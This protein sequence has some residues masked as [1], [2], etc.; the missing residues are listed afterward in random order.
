MVSVLTWSFLLDGTEILSYVL[1]GTKIERNRL[2]ISGNQATIQ[3]IKNIT[4]IINIT[5]GMNIIIKR[6]TKY[7]FRGR[8]KIIKEEDNNIILTCFDY[9]QELK[10]LLFSKSYDINIDSQAGEVA[11]IAEDIIIN[12]GFNASV[13]TSTTFL[14][15]FNSR[16]KSRLNRLEVLT[17][18]VNYILYYDYDSD[19]VKFEPIGLNTYANPLIIGSN[20]YNVPIWEEDLESVRNKIRIEGAYKEDTFIEYFNGTGSQ[21]TFTLEFSPIITELTVDNGAGFITQKLGIEN[22]SENYDYTTDRD[23]KTFTFETASIPSAGSNNIIM[24]YTGRVPTPVTKSN[25][26]SIELYGVTQEED[27]NFSDVVT[28]DDA[29]TRVNELLSLLSFATVS[30]MLVTDEY[31]LDLGNVIYVND[32]NN[33][34]RS[35]NYIVHGIVHNY[36]EPVDYVKVG[37]VDFDVQQFFNSVEERIRAL[38]SPDD[39]LSELL[40]QIFELAMI[41]NYDASYLKVSKASKDSGVLYWDDDTQGTWDD[42]DWGDDTEESFVI[43]RIVQRNNTYREFLMDSEF[44]DV[45]NTTATVDSTLNTI[46]FSSGQVF[47][48]LA[49]SLGVAHSFFTL[50]IGNQSGSLLY[51]VSADNGVSFQT[52]SSL[53]VRTA[54]VSSD[55]TGIILRITENNSSSA[56]LEPLRSIN[57]TLINPAISLF[58]EVN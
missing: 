50:N 1:P 32:V 5:A 51:E 47:Q 25:P 23:L 21:D 36:P 34:S 20:V 42:F 49:V 8:I 44:V 55:A 2:N 33:P 46:S 45:L 18:V 12:G 56:S 57:D 54:Y 14:K 58:S 43:S 29:E 10:Y 37:D 30:T 53:N 13:V 16:R 6:G 28:V 52:I 4:D 38:E 41:I 15:K 39:I 27:F 19:L 17:N 9:L 26:S 3:V 11:A 24:K 7:L 22:S 48:T 40:L 35:G 31:S